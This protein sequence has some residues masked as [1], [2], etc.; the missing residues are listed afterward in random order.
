M[1]KKEDVKFECAF[2]YELE[3]FLPNHEGEILLRP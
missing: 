2:V 3:H 1:I